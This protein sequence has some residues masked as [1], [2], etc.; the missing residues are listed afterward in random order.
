MLKKILMLMLAMMVA[1]GAYSYANPPQ[2]DL[3]YEYY[4]MKEHDSL[5]RV[6]M[7]Y[8]GKQDK[9]DDPQYVLN[10]IVEAN[11]LQSMAAVIMLGP[12]TVI[13]IPLYKEVE[14]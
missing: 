1:Y 12:G 2:Y 6:A 11:G 14:K 9:Y 8:C 7:K 5:W 4:V 13:K 3:T 10:D